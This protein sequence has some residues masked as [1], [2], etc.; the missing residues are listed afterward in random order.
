MPRSVRPA[1][2]RWWAGLL[3]LLAL[4][5]SA[6]GNR[7]YPVR[8]KVVYKDN[9]RPVPGGVV[10]WFE[11]TTPPHARASGVVGAD[12]TFVLSTNRE[13]SGAIQGEHRVRFEPV[14]P[15]AE[16]DAEAALARTMPP[17][18]REYRT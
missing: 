7:T 3:A 1:R 18:Y 12:G 8:G 16:P 13:G 11:S 17:R 2:R 14:V 5:A 6:C 4:S 9:G 10:I 15:F